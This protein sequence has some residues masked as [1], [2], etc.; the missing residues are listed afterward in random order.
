MPYYIA[1]LPML[2]FCGV[3]GAVYSLIR[4]RRRSALVFGI[5]G[6]GSAVMAITLYYSSV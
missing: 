1:L 2:A 4:R 6:V 3:V 5:A